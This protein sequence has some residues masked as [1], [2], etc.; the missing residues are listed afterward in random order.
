MFEIR[1]NGMVLTRAETPNYIRQHPK[2][3]YYLCDKEDAMGVAV[4]GTPYSFTEGGMSNC[5]V[6]QLVE[7]DAGKILHEQ[8]LQLNSLIDTVDILVM[9]TLM[10]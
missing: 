2:G 4:N 6:V 7:C 8:I 3:F 9:D 5:E 10:K 1:K